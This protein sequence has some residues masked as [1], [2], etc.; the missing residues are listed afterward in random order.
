MPCYLA[1]LER[2]RSPLRLTVSQLGL[3][4]ARRR[5]CRPACC[6][7]PTQHLLRPGRPRAAEPGPGD[8]LRRVPARHAA[9]PH[10]QTLLQVGVRMPQ[11]LGES[12]GG[13]TLGGS[14]TRR[15]LPSWR[16][17]D[18]QRRV[19]PELCFVERSALVQVPLPGLAEESLPAAGSY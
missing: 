3:R 2:L 11:Q 5:V 17:K 10:A 14:L 8:A 16:T 7:P 6:E 4:Q 15:S 9:Q 1:A 12:L 13:L 18:P 19:L